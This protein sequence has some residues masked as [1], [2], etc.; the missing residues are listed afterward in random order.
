[1]ILFG[2]IFPNLDKSSIA[3][4]N[5]QIACNIGADDR[6]RGNATARFCPGTSVLLV[7]QWVETGG[8]THGAVQLIEQQNSTYV[9]MEENAQTE[10]V[11][12]CWQKCTS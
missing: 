10:P 7:D 12:H 11:T 1:M 8:T 2:S 6:I 3:G 5:R 4:L 9:V